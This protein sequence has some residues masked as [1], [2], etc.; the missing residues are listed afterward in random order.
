[1]NKKILIVDETA[2]D[3]MMLNELLLR[4]G[5]DVV[6]QTNEPDAAVR[7]YAKLDPDIVIMDINCGG[8][9]ALKEIK[10]VDPSACIV[11]S[12][13]LGQEELVIEAVKNGANE[14]F[15]K[16]FKSSIVLETLEK[17]MN[18]QLL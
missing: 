15:I 7:L 12:C 11:M 1:M 8:S 6:G 16:P 4:N 14:F 5:Y 13:S 2:Y 10:E 17:A 3:R 9:E 18:K